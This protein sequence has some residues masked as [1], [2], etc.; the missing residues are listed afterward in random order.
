MDA[1]LAD[2]KSSDSLSISEAARKHEVGRSALSRRFNRKATSAAQY[3]DSTR[4]LNNAQERELLK[5]IR[6]LCERC[7]PPTPKIVANIAQELCGKAP[8][9]NW[10]TRFVARNRDQL[11]A[12]YL[13]TLDL[14]RHKA[15]SRASYEQYFDILN[16]RIK[17]YDILPENMYNMDEKGFLIGRLQKTQ[18][19]FT[20]D[21]YKQ[22]KLVGAGQD[23]SREW[24]TVVATICADGTS[25]SPTVIYKAVSGDLRDTWLEDFEPS[26]QSC[27]FTSSP[28]GWTTDELGYSWLTGLFEKET[29]AK[30]KGSWRLLFV[31]GHGSH[32]NMKFLNWCEQNRILVAIYLPHSTHRLQPLDVSV[33]APLAHH[34]SQGLDSL[35]RQSEGHAAMSKRDFFAIFWPAFEKAFTQTNIASAWSKTGI[36]PFN[37]K[38]VLAMF[39]SP[40]E[41]ITEQ[42]SA[43][44]SASGSSSSA[45]DSPSKAKKLRTIVNGS[46]A[47]IDK[48]TRRTLDKLGDAILGL[49][50]KLTLSRLRNK[51]LETAL[52]LEQKKKKRQRKVLEELRSSEGSGALIMSP[53][54]IQ[55]ARDLA[56]SREQ[57]KE[58]LARDKESRAQ[59]RSKE[60]ARKQEEAQRKREDRAVASAARKEA[61]AEKKAARAKAKADKMASKQLE[62]QS[63]V[64]RRRSRGRPRSQTAVVSA[65]ASPVRPVVEK[66]SKQPVTRRGRNVR[67]P[68]RYDEF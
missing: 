47:G 7:L 20:K 27:Y 12:R 56:M 19:V 55:R 17:D 58:Q 48:R 14:A 65:K 39:S 50:A 67:R 16:T 51:Q 52:R 31:D 15:D 42:L 36:V 11:D 68:A 64:A 57:E 29:A 38:E 2:L 63:G 25:L 28:K 30:A 60:K 24:I 21:L 1:A 5:Y 9:K 43:E 32:V 61:A 59:E 18:R 54:K 4:L 6:S 23:G 53:T 34:Y 13:N 37:P 33:F 35:I 26:Q 45:F 46:T 3:H 66:S 44:R 8:S 41:N 10:A 62:N 22:G 49:S 40:S